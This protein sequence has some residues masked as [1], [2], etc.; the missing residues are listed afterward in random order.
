[1]IFFRLVRVV[2]DCLFFS[3]GE[4]S[5]CFEEKRTYDVKT[6]V[7]GSRIASHDWSYNHA[8]DFNNASIIARRILHQKISRIFAHLISLNAGKNLAHFQDDTALFF[9]KVPDHLFN[10]KFHLVKIVLTFSFPNFYLI[11]LFAP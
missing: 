3:R 5:A 6:E 8:I 11:H 4:R 2:L 1:M 10:P 7:K 9:T